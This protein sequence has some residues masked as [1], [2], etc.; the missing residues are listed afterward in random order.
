MLFL[1]M[2]SVHFGVRFVCLVDQRLSFRA[3]VRSVDSQ[4]S[5]DERQRR[6]RRRLTREDDEKGL[7]TL[8]KQAQTQKTPSL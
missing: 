5:D 4:D 1:F 3:V 7:L 6:R 2:L 8:P